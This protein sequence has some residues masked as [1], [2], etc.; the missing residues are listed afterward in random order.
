M[1]E[2]FVNFNRL[3]S[4]Y[5]KYIVNSILSVDKDSEIFIASNKNIYQ[6]TNFINLEDFQSDDINEFKSI[7]VYKNTIFESN[8]LWI[9]SALRV[10]I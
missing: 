1:N 3:Q 4:G 9:N 7:N 10:F 5:I 2:I 8:P 6:N